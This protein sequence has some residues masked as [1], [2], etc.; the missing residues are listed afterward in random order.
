VK[1]NYRAS[2]LEA[3]RA[4]EL[5]PHTSFSLEDLSEFYRNKGDFASALQYAEQASK[6]DPSF[7]VYRVRA[8]ILQFQGMYRES[9]TELE[10]AIAR[11]PQ[12]SWLRGALLAMSYIR[13]GELAKAENEIRIAESMDPDKPETHITRAML[14]TV[15]GHIR[16]AQQELDTIEN[17]L[18]RDYALASYAAAIYARQH[19]TERAL[20]AMDDAMRL[21]NRWY[22]WYL[23]AWFDGIRTE[24]RFQSA[25]KNLKQELDEITAGLEPHQLPR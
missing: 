14:Y 12:D 8:R 10:R 4:I 21:G 24:P 19:E 13:L 17:F 22:S 9:V 6:A 15:Q 1:G 23:D 25:L 11:S 5:D 2:I 20:A 7:N 3:V 16:Q 18:H